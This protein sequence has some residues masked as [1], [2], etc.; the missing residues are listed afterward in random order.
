MTETFSALVCLLF[1]WESL[2]CLLYPLM[3]CITSMRL[4]TAIK[5]TRALLL[6]AGVV[7]VAL[8]GMRDLVDVPRLP[9]LF[10]PVEL[11]S[12]I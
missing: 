6:F 3:I 10:Y 2:I 12:R 7:K 4:F 5:I 1:H 11:L 9:I 8:H